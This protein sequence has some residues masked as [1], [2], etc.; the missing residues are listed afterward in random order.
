MA[1]KWPVGNRYIYRL[2][3]TQQSTNKVA[4][5]TNP[6]S[7]DVA[8]GLTYALSVLNETSDGGRQLEVEFIAYELQIKVGG[9]LMIS[10][11][12]VQNPS[13]A[14]GQPIPPPFKKLIG[15]KLRLLVNTQGT[16]TKVIEMDQWVKSLVGDREGPA[17]QMLVQQFN[18]GFF[19]QMTDFGRGLPGRNVRVGETWPYT[20]E[21]P[22]GDLGTILVTS[23]IQLKDWA[24]EAD[25]KFAVLES[26]GTLAGKPA[27]QADTG[28]QLFLDQGTVS[29]RSW[30]DPELG[31]LM[32]SVVEQSM[33]LKGQTVSSDPTD[34][35]GSEFTSEIG[36]KV[37]V[38]LVEWAHSNG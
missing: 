23:Q 26:R 18:Y 22:A 27:E 3:L 13:E 30:F 11:D 6:T 37:V 32:E 34:I 10:F 31:A 33:R 17:G 35:D 15:S 21:V 5:Q 1:V 9:Q 16:L 14:A 19:Q 20:A 28:G 24:G 12:A 2:D 8:M 38:K 7:E 4:C 36:Q 25:Q 29:G